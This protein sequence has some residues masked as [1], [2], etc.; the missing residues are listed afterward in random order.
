[1]NELKTGLYQLAQESLL[2]GRS[3][4]SEELLAREFGVSRTKIRENLKSLEADGLLIARQGQGRRV[5]PPDWGR[6]LAESW[7]T[8][9]LVDR[10][11]IFNLFAIRR[12]LEQGFLAEAIIRINEEQIA[13]MRSAADDMERAARQGESFIDADHRFH[14]L[15][16]AS[17][18]NP[19]LHQ[20]LEAFWASLNRAQAASPT[21]DALQTVAAHRHLLEA[22]ESRDLAAASSFLMLQ[23][24]D[25]DRRLRSEQQE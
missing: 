22:L 19:L 15:L 17:I 20:L 25:I 9:F 1:M 10:Q 18:N 21:N 14:Q 6:A 13:G 4:P 23:F 3:F 12:V 2:A 11:Q 5:Q 24:V 16:Y 8:V 7:Q